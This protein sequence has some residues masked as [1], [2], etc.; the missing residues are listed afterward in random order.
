MGKLQR[1]RKVVNGVTYVYERTP[2]YNPAIK[3]QNIS[4]SMQAVKRQEKLKRQDHLS[5]KVTDLSH[6]YTCFVRSGKPRHEGYPHHHLTGGEGNE[7]LALV[8]SKVVKPLPMGSIS[9]WYEGPYR[10]V[11]IPANFKS[12]RVS[13]L[14]ENTGSSS[15][16]RE[17]SMELIA[18]IHSPLTDRIS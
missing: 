5:R 15:L 14:P 9:T 3:T 10:I 4:I 16:Y 11:A 12:Q 6:F 8:I 7:T 2:Y 13:D 1:F 18:P 17:L